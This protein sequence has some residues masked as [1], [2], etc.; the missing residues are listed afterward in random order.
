[1]GTISGFFVEE[2]SLVSE[3]ELIA[4]INPT[5][6]LSRL[7]ELEAKIENKTKTNPN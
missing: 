2:G 6:A 4:T 7:E 3:G 5:E 1:M